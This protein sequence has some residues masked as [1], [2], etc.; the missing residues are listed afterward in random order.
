MTSPDGVS[1]TLGSGSLSATSSAYAAYGSDLVDN[2]GTPVWVGNPGSTTG[3]TW[4]SGVAS[5]IPA[6]A[7]SDGRMLLAGCCAYSAA[8]ARDAG[9]GAVY[10]A[11][12]S[13][14]NATSEQGIQVGQILPSPGAFSQAPG[15]IVLRDG[16][17]SSLDPGQ[18]IAMAAR[19]GGG[20][21]VAY[22]VGYP[23][24]TGIRVLQVGTANTLDVPGSKDAKAISLSADASGRLWVS[25]VIS[26]RLKVAHTNT[27]ASAFGAVGS[28]GAPRGTGTL[29]HTVSAA[30][31]G[32]LDVVVNAGGPGGKINFWHTQT[33]RTLSVKARPASA[34]RGGAVTFTVSDAGDPVAG[35]SVR[36]GSRSGTTNGAGKVTITATSRGGV[37]ATARKSGFNAGMTTVRVR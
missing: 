32:A 26:N 15:S 22:K 29:W 20:V 18:R 34:H 6:P 30:G 7:G 5:T 9:T 4:H 17:A 13:N 21:Y 2:A 1:W 28:W 37:R 10:A 16:A 14:S 3:V 12:Y 23:T 19:P 36:F 27:A 11:F 25:W 33:L 24:V 35:A 8:A 31:N